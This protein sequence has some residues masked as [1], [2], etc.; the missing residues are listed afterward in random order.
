MLKKTSLLRFSLA[1]AST[2]STASLLS[3][4]RGDCSPDVFLCSEGGGSKFRVFV[5]RSN[6]RLKQ[7]AR[8]HLPTQVGNCST[9]HLL[10]LGLASLQ[11]G[12]PGQQTQRSGIELDAIRDC[13]S[14][15]LRVLLCFDCKYFSFRE[16]SLRRTD[17]LVDSSNTRR[18]VLLSATRSACQS[19]WI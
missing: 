18:R 2:A 3:G 17:V 9:K 14:L 10:F 5:G 16:L 13:K 1:F 11:P 6:Q 7:P 4:F 8:R 15:E 19:S 12:S